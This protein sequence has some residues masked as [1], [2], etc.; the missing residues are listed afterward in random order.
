MSL[1]E[2]KLIIPEP[3]FISGLNSEQKKAVLDTEGPNLI[4]AGAGSG[5]TRVLTTKLAYIINEKRLLRPFNFEDGTPG[6]GFEI[7]SKKNAKV[8]VM[9]IMGNIHMKKCN[10]IQFFNMNS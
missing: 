2:E 9:N 8:G 3:D 5:K 1:V 4:V 7:Y 10:F 6:S